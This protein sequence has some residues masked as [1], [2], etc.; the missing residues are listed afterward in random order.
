MW[1]EELGRVISSKQRPLFP[2]QGSGVFFYAESYFS[3]S[4]SVGP[5]LVFLFYSGKY[6][7]EAGECEL[8]RPENI[9]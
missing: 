7:E 5:P 8:P 6:P 2:V 1:R 9:W 3:T 4:E